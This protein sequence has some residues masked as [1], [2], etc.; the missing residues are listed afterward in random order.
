MTVS[1][2]DASETFATHLE[3]WKAWQRAPWS[4]L[5]YSVAGANLA[6]HLPRG[7]LQVLD[8]GGGN[9]LDAI[10]LAVSGH[11]VTIADFSQAM[12]AEARRNAKEAHVLGNIDFVLAPADAV[13]DHLPQE[14]FD[15]VLSHN[16]LQYLD[17]PRRM[18]DNLRDVLRTEGILSIM[19]VNRHSEVYRTILQSGDAVDALAQLEARTHTA[20]MF[21]RE[22]RRYSADE[23]VKLLNE[24]GFTVV[25]EYGIRCFVDYITDNER[26]FDSAY[27]RDLERLEMEASRR[28]PFKHAA[29]FFQLI[30][31]KA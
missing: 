16:L 18:F 13:S 4:K 28:F 19:S 27:F 23:I 30:A 15:V 9:G 25:G 11:D 31:Q 22:V 6:G 5:R 29:R 26:K 2:P 14:G 7:A 8:L 21:E 17:D 3:E 20:G 1:E 10:P 12:L 24:G